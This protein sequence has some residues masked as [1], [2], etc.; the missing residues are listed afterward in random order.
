ML[1]V[2]LFVKFQYISDFNSETWGLF[3]AD[4]VPCSAVQSSH[5]VTHLAPSDLPR[6]KTILEWHKHFL[7]CFPACPQLREKSHSWPWAAP[8]SD[9]DKSG[10]N[11]LLSLATIWCKAQPEV[12]ECSNFLVLSF[13][14]HTTMAKYHW[15]SLHA[16]LCILILLHCIF[17]WYAE[18]PSDRSW[19]EE[20]NS[21]RSLA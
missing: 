17:D 15:S 4:E 6:V 2:E 10:S 21:G 14:N 1:V 9:E 11:A 5:T 19:E 7:C 3:G 20:A 16:Y 12:P 18:E 8:K 13:R